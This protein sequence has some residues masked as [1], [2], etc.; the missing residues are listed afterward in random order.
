MQSINHYAR[1]F[2]AIP[3]A[4]L[5]VIVL[6]F[7]KQDHI[8]D[9]VRYLYYCITSEGAVAKTKPTYNDR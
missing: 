3:N 9:A 6:S 4:K 5:K 2:Y 8:A 1:L 7:Y